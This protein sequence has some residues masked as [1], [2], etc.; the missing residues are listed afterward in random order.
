MSPAERPLYDDMPRAAPKDW[1]NTLSGRPCSWCMYIVW[2]GIFSL[3]VAVG[4]A[5]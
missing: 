3:G 4:L 1:D 5:L 2:L